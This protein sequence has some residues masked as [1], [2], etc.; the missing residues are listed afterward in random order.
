MLADD[1]ARWAAAAR[2][3]EASRARSRQRWLRR[4]AEDEATFAGVLVDLA[5]REATVL[6]RTTSGRR[7]RAIVAV[8]GTDFVL[9]R[10]EGDR[11]LLLPFTAVT[12]VRPVEE[13]GRTAAGRRAPTV[14]LLLGEA[15]EVMAGDR[16][17]VAVVAA[18]DP[19]PT[20][21]EL[22]AV[23]DDVLTVRVGA[24]SGAR[25]YVRLEAVTEIGVTA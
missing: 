22:E 23:G 1:L 17:S 13:Q 5:E 11:W 18:A 25:A 20:V 7:H 9:V 8:V 15:L 3:D 2:A 14:D 21:G 19:D 6:M 16:A 10:A 4:Q 12:T 24:P